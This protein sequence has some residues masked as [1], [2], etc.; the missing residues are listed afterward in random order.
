[1]NENSCRLG[2]NYAYVDLNEIAGKLS[3]HDKKVFAR[4][5]SFF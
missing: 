3:A 5:C 1:M 2:G 4:F